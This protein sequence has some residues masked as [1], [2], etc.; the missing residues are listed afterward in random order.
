LHDQVRVARHAGG[1]A[2]RLGAAHDLGQRET[3]LRRS[4]AQQAAAAARAACH[5]RGACA[6]NT[7]TKGRLL[8]VDDEPLQLAAL[9]DTLAMEGYATRGFGSPREALAG[10]RPGMY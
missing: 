4:R 1:A 2:H 10:L 5:L 9:C 6:M 7:E 8:I 3:G